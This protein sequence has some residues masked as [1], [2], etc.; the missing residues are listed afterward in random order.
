[1]LLA[2]AA[3]VLYTQAPDVI[4]TNY[5]RYIVPG[6]IIGSGGMQVALLATM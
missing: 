6:M 5:W 3:L 4:G 1:M 2:G